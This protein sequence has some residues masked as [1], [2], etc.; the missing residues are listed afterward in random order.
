MKGIISVDLFGQPADYENIEKI[1]KK[2]NL[3]ILVDAAQSFGA[4]YKNI[5]VGKF[6]ATAL[7][8]I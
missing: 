1:A 8:S 6:S 7:V 3:W 4:T 2:N 5:K